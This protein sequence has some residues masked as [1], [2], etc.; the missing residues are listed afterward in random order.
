MMKNMSTC[1]CPGVFER[2]HVGG[3][4]TA[5]FGPY[6][7]KKGVDISGGTLFTR[8]NREDVCYLCYLLSIKATQHTTTCSIQS[9]GRSAVLDLL[10][11]KLVKVK[12][13]G[14]FFCFK[15]IL[16][17]KLQL[18]GGHR[19]EQKPS[20][21][22]DRGFQ[23]KWKLSAAAGIYQ[24]TIMFYLIGEQCGRTAENNSEKGSC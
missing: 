10:R 12:G 1:H 18:C 19:T 15:Y 20:L 6:T 2:A 4:Y 8:S 13:Q 3:G 24:I 14:P 16:K 23:N 11:F 5:F 7:N 9:G 17:N 22:L 21:C